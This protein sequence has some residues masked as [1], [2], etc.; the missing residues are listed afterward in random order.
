MWINSD[1]PFQNIDIFTLAGKEMKKA[2]SAIKL[3]TKRDPR[4]QMTGL[5][6]PH[7]DKAAKG[8]NPRNRCKALG[9]PSWF[10]SQRPLTEMNICCLSI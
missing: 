1:Q 6:Q 10:Q 8:E 3:V 9:R 5:K 7:R 4:G 2:N